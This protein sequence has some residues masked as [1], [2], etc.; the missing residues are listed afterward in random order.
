MLVLLPCWYKQHPSLRSMFVSELRVFFPFIQDHYSSNL[1]TKAASSLVCA[2]RTY[3]A[4]LRLSYAFRKIF[5]GQENIMARTCLRMLLTH[6]LKRQH[7]TNATTLCQQSV[8]YPLFS[9]VDILLLMRVGIKRSSTTQSLIVIK[10]TNVAQNH[11]FNL[12][13]GI[14]TS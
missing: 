9:S 6:I 8:L 3:S 4:K 12:S 11:F 13:F 1:I 7:N 2:S 5:H 10:G 14:N